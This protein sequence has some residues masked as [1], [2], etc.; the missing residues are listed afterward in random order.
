MGR[1]QRCLPQAACGTFASGSSASRGLLAAIHTGE[2][3]V[4]AV[5]ASGGRGEVEHV[6]KLFSSGF[7]TV[8]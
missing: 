6:N 3:D 1:G 8:I 4:W 5:Q 2:E 7:Y